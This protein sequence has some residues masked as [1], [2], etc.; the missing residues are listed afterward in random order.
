MLRGYGFVT[1][2]TELCVTGKVDPLLTY[3]IVTHV[4]T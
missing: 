1:G 2:V 3:I 4:F